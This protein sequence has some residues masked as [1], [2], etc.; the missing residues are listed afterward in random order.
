MLGICGAGPQIPPLRGPGRTG[1][2]L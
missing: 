1:R 2:A